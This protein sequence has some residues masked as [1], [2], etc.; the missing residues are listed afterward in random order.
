MLASLLAAAQPTIADTQYSV[1]P[2]T[3]RLIP[4]PVGYSVMAD[5]LAPHLPPPGVDPGWAAPPQQ[6]SP[7]GTEADIRLCQFSANAGPPPLDNA[8]MPGPQPGDNAALQPPPMVPVED[9]WQWKFLPSGL[10]YPAY[11]AGVKEARFGSEWGSSSDCG[12]VMDSTLGAH[13]G[14]VRY[15]AVDGLR[16]EGWQWDVEGASFP[17]LTYDGGFEVRASDYS[18]GT[19]LTNRLGMWEGKL[20]YSH[21][22]AHLGDSFAL[23]NP[24]FLRNGYIRDDLTLGLGMRPTC[25]LRFYFETIYGVMAKGGAEPWGFQFGGEYLH[26]EPED[27]HGGPF[28]AVNCHLRQENNFAGNLSVTTGWAWRSLGDHLARVGLHYFNGYS[29]QYQFYTRYEDE[30]GAGLWYD[31]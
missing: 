4:A 24:T 15:G 12:R 2:P 18:F 14:L 8:P 3:R 16:P 10:L 31:F 29:E 26:V 23:E 7:P 6:P 13:V 17:R 9:A 21:F 20:G 28:F 25:D 11:L 22:C 1:A 30:F 5:S 27:W 19:L